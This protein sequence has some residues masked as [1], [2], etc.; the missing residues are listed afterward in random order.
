MPTTAISRD[1][2]IEEYRS[3]LSNKQVQGARQL[4]LTLS[5][6]ADDAVII[7]QVVKERLHVIQRLWPSKV[8]QQ[9]PNLLFLL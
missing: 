9:D 8:E 7:E 6:E 4:K 3:Q 5:W 2:L 1:S